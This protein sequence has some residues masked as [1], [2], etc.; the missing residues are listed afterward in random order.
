MKNT[1]D[2]KAFRTDFDKAVES[3]AKKYNITLKAGNITYDDTSFT[4][5]VKAVRTDIDAEKQQFISNVQYMKYYGFTEDDYKRDFFIN[6]KKYTIIGFKPG[7]KYDVV[8]R[9]DGKEY[10]LVSN[11]VLQALG[12]R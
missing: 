8:A 9:K 4:L 3:L 1:I 11:A 12:R 5:K 2:F 10:A 7:N 6:G